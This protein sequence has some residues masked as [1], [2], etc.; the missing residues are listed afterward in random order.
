[1][2]QTTPSSYR[3]ERAELRER[4]RNAESEAERRE[5]VLRLAEI[6]REIQAETYEKLARE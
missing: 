5:A 6:N 4:V 3:D 1:M 2:A